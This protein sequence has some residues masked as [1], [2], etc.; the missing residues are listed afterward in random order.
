MKL[1]TYESTRSWILMILAVLW[2]F[3]AGVLIL[4]GAHI[5][6]SEKFD[7]ILLYG[8]ILINLAFNVLSIVYLCSTP[9]DSPFTDHKFAEFEIEQCQPAPMRSIPLPTDWPSPSDSSNG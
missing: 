3:N 9:L 1:K 6:G 7:P 2:V 4:F 8:S 5:L